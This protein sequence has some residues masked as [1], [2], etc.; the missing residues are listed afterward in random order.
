MQEPGE[1]TER[2][3]Q[4]ESELPLMPQTN[5]SQLPIWKLRVQ[6]SATALN[7]APPGSW[8]LAPGSW[9]LAPGSCE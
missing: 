6:C 2:A 9:L 8:L 7:P 1:H 4:T 5:R 3:I